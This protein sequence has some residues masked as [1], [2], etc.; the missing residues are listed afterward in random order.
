MPIL[1]PD[2]GARTLLVLGASSDQTFL[3]HTAQA[4]GLRVLAVDMNPAAPGLLEADEAEIVSTRDVP[5]L[6][7]MIDRRRASSGADFAGV[8]TMGSDMPQVIAELAQHLGTPSVSRR[9]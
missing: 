1:V 6:I 9:R 2:A 3:I 5:A 4:T 7:R 8:L